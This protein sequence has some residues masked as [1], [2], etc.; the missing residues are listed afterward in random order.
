MA[1]TSAV[2][3]SFAFTNNSFA[4]TETVG[5]TLITS[6][7]IATTDVSDMDFGTWL[8]QIGTVDAGAG[9]VIMTITDDTTAAVSVAGI[10][11]SQVVQI[12]APTTE[13][14]VNV[15]IPAPGTLSM[16]R[17]ALTDFGDA[18]LSLTTTSWQQVGGAGTADIANGASV[19]ITVGAG[20][21]DEVIHFGADITMSATPADDTHTASF[22]VTFTY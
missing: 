3:L 19:N 5:A 21:V 14:V 17:G 10:S 7:T 20:G 11:D 15:Q 8:V 2:A 12:I 16:T 6:S 9:D 4:Q 13:A 18:G 1:L 22:P